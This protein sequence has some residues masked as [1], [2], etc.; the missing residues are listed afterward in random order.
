MSAA[1]SAAAS[2]AVPA[3]SLLLVVILTLVWGCNWP[4]LK[5]GVTEL[6]PLTFRAATL[7]FA[8]LGLLTVSKLSGDSIRIARALWPKVAARANKFAP[9]RVRE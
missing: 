7:P 4:V 3:S 9:T 6:A 5:L 1:P 2:H 8:A